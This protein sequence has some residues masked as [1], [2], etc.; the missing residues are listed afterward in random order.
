[1]EGTL[2]AAERLVEFD[3]AW[4]EEPLLPEDFEGYERLMRESPIPI[5]SGEHEYT[6]RGFEALMQRGLHA[7]YQ[8][9]VCWCGGLT[10]LV[11]IYELAKHYKV[12]VCPASRGRSVGAARDCRARSRST[13]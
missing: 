1:M 7:I 2:R 6:A 11:K 5:A 8:P 3:L 12:E 13:G 10:E 9:D 4:L